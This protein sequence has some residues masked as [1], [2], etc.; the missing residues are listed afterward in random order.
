[1]SAAGVCDSAPHAAPDMLNGKL[2]VG[3]N[4]TAN[5]VDASTAAVEAATE[6]NERG[7]LAGHIAAAV[8]LQSQSR[9]DG[10]L[11]WRFLF[12]GFILYFVTLVGDSSGTN[13]C[14]KRYENK[15]LQLLIL[16]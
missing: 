3:A 11:L 9:C 14:M 5:P 12:K 2:Q 15:H 13:E 10:I 6:T 7:A 4:G 8:R 16:I 1:M